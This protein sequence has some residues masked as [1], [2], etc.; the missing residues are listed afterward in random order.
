MEKIK[1]EQFEIKPI[2]KTPF[3]VLNDKEKKETWIILGNE[4]IKQVTSEEEAMICARYYD[5]DIL[6]PT[7]YKIASDA[8]IRTM[9]QIDHWKKTK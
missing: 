9:E 4:K 7:I 8:T 1:N 6:G 2:E 5:W 3:A